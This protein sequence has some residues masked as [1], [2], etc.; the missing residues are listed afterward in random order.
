VALE[1]SIIDD[2]SGRHKSSRGKEGESRLILQFL[3]TS[4]SGGVSTSSIF[5]HGLLDGR[6]HATFA[7]LGVEKLYKSRVTLIY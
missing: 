6:E 4:K 3:H 2:C 1:L 7:I 5:P